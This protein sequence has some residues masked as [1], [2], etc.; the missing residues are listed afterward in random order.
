MRRC[1][2]GFRLGCPSFGGLVSNVVVFKFAVD[3]AKVEN[4]DRGGYPCVAVGQILA[5]TAV[6]N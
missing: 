4:D 2:G 1:K 5:A 6:I 3:E